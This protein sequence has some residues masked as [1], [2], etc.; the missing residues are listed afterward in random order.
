MASPSIFSARGLQAASSEVQVR[1]FTRS[2]GF[3]PAFLFLT[4]V[5]QTDLHLSVAASEKGI[6]EAKYIPIPLVSSPPFE[7]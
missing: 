6:K 4:K 2:R 1:P 7:L 3:F 5:G